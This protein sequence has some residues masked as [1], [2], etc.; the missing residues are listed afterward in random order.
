[1]DT[2][3]SEC[4][5][6]MYVY[7]YYS[8]RYVY[9]YIH[10]I[11][12]SCVLSDVG[13][14][15]IYT[16]ITVHYVAL[17]YIASNYNTLQLITLQCIP[18]GTASF[19]MRIML[20]YITLQYNSLLYAISHHYIHLH[21]KIRSDTTSMTRSYGRVPPRDDPPGPA[22]RTWGQSPSGSQRRPPGGDL[23]VES[24]G[25]TNQYIGYNITVIIYIYIY[26]YHIILYIS[27]IIYLQ[28]IH[29]FDTKVYQ[30]YKCLFNGLTFHGK[31]E[32]GNHPF[33]H[34]DHGIFRYFSQQNQSI[35]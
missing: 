5:H 22:A 1:M 32:T 26:T 4:I 33:S 3:T 18:L 27:N 25:T 34:D 15:G 21:A 14:Y 20:H 23:V 16:Y 7:T 29:I 24:M 9:I 28:Y 17:H 6:V 10:I 8:N 12:H 31:I 11:T 35:D 19:C 13:I 30:Y 2:H